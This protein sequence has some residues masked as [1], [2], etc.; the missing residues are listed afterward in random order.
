MAAG[1]AG[2]LGARVVLLEKN[3]GLGVKLLMTGG[4]R[5]NIANSIKESRKLIEEYGKNG[6]FLFSS[7]MRFGTDETVEF[8]ESRGVKTKVEADGRIFPVSN[9]AKDVLKSLIKYLNEFKVEIKTNSAVKEIISSDGKIEKIILT[10]GEEI[11]AEKYI[12]CVGGKS[13]SASGSTGDGYVWL[14][15]LGH[16]IVSPAPALV[17]I[18][19]KGKLTKEL[20]G[21][22]LKQVAITLYDGDKKAETQ[23][24]EM[25]F[26]ADGLSG[27]LALNLS[28][29]VSRLLPKKMKL[30]L[31]FYPGYSQSELDQKIQ[32]DFKSDNN[33]T[34]KNFLNKLLQPK[35]ATLILKMSGI[36]PDKQ[37]NSVSKEE[38][39]KLVA[40]LKEFDLEIYSL[41]GFDKAMVTSGGV[42]LSEVD[43]KT[44]KSKLVSNLYLAGEILDLEGPTG[45][46]NLQICWT[47]GYVA[48]ENA[49]GKD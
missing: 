2:E 32:S 43:P 20:E 23:S 26:T 11:I 15:N 47:T 39:K 28:R 12:V 21:L 7:L 41:A 18:I 35:L 4:G 9:S 27:P 6:K 29:T 17:P 5:C 14:K 25:I 49:V 42:K 33:K 38:R 8:F 34:F 10:N 22:S 16:E 1:R 37:V 44:M 30:R 13:Y 3:S 48:G 36:K 31:D 40:L 46:Y 45:G 24:G 19:T